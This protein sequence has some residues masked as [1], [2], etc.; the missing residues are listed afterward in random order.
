MIS[1]LHLKLNGGWYIGGVNMSDSR[2]CIVESVCFSD[3]L[4]V[5]RQGTQLLLDLDQTVMQTKTAV[6]GDAWFEK[7]ITYAVTIVPDKAD[8]IATVIAI[9]H[10]VQHHV[11]AIA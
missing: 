6:G 4:R 10:E 7:L 11:H 9:Y 1:V 3:I 2:S 8:A 5:V